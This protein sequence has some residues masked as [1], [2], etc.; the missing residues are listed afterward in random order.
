[1]HH[2][3]CGRPTGNL[4]GECDPCTERDRVLDEAETVVDD[5]MVR[6]FGH[7]PTVDGPLR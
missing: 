4:T 7:G 3:D 1:M 6:L 2:C 5:E